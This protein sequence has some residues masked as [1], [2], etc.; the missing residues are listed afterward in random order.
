MNIGFPA[1]LVAVV[2]R[3]TASIL[4]PEVLMM[5]RT[6]LATLGL[7]V[8]PLFPSGL[9]IGPPVAVSQE[10]DLAGGRGN[11]PAVERPGEP[12]LTSP[13]R[14]RRCQPLGVLTT[15][16]RIHVRCEQ[17]VREGQDNIVYFAF[18]TSKPDEAERVLSVLLTAQV[19]R[20]EINV[21][22]HSGREELARQIG[23]LF[24][25][26]RLL[27]AVEMQQVI[28]LGKKQAQAAQKQNAD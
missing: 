28:D 5:R 17:T 18:P 2:L 4:T 12:V 7:Y 13:L 23:C 14:W 26:C 25:D 3:R 21:Q 22:Y 1:V 11:L 27:V 9:T 19:A 15:G 16:A 10:V 8:L 6:L 20:R 24:N